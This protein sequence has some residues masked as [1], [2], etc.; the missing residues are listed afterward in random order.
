MSLARGRERGSKA[1]LLLGV[2]LLRPP[3]SLL[4]RPAGQPKF[5]I[6][7][8]GQKGPQGKA[9]SSLVVLG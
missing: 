9:L 7:L 1:W 6:L 8:Y 3:R 5:N 4:R 2:W